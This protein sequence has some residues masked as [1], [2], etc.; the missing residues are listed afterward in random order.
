MPLHISNP[1][2]AHRR[3]TTFVAGQDAEG[4]PFYQPNI[5]QEYRAN[6]SVTRGQLVQWVAPTA[7]VPLSVTPMATASSALIFAGVALND[8]TAGETVQVAQHGHVLVNTGDIT[9]SLGEYLV[10]PA[11]TAGV[12]TVSS[13]AIDATTVVGSTLGIVVG[14]DDGTFTPV[15]LNR[16]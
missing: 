1:F 16:L 15:F 4:E 9:T 12:G 10:K 2:G 5:I 14:N 6:A 13:T 7:T 11:T 8:A 3:V